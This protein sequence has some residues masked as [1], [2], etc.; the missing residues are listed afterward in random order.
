M[1]YHLNLNSLVTKMLETLLKLFDKIKKVISM[2]SSQTAGNGHFSMKN[3]LV[4][5]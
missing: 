4:K 5:Y 1:L 2:K 3:I